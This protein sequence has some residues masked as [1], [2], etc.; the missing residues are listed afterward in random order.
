MLE[1]PSELQERD[2]EWSALTEFATRL[3]RGA[4]LG[5][6]YGR[7]RQ[8]K[9][10][11]LELL[12]E[13]VG[14]FMFTASQQYGPEN[15]R[16]LSESYRAYV[17]IEDPV[18]FAN[19]Q[20][21]VDALLRLGERSDKPTLVVLDEFPYLL[22][23]E[24]ALPSL[25]Q[26]AMSPRSRASRQSRT[27]IILCGS[28]L[29][30]MR[31]LLIGTAPLRGRAVLEMNLPPFGYREAAHLWDL[32]DNPE[33]AF[34]VNALIGGTPAYLGMSNGSVAGVRDFDDW[35]ARGLLNP[36]SAIFREGNTL[37]YEQPELIDAALYFSVLNAIASGAC[38]R[39]EI[40]GRL[41][42]PDASLTHPLALLEEINLIEKIED[43]LVSRRPVFRITEPVIRFHQLVIRSRE[44]RIVG[45]NG[46]SVWDSVQDT[47][48]GKIYGPHFEDLAREW[49]L[50]HASD[51][52]CGGPPTRVRPATIACKEHRQGHELDVVVLSDPPYETSRVLAVGEAKASA[53]PIGVQALERLEH[54]RD[55]VP[56]DKAVAEVKLLLF[57]R[58]GFTLELR[59]LAASR[60]DV[61]LIDLARLYGGS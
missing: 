31:E 35:V 45:L 61:E 52:T 26:I 11:M 58:G 54:L 30:T 43:A 56:G 51:E 1:K 40:A 53:H 17:G 16:A 15:L 7:R 12:C 37:L 19:W 59:R 38:R 34:R 60:A 48:E 49:T 57:A 39:S 28:A 41:G 33:L 25:L 24:P 20:E 27:R 50:K 8:G 21:A 47:V 4:L 3:T 13:A 42:R 6:V 36:V 44:G 14:G 5:L 32:A 55:L 10:F 18:R 23:S 46:R 2:F 9:T 29:A 22:D